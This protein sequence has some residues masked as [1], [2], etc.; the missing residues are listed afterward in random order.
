MNARLSL[1]IAALCL[2]LA[3]A[4]LGRWQWQRGEEKAA[5]LAAWNAALTAPDSALD[6][7]VAATGNLPQRVRGEGRFHGPW[8]L[9]DNQRHQGVVGLRV[10]R[11]LEVCCEGHNVLVDLGWR[12]W[13]EGRRAPA[14]VEL[15]DPA[16]VAG[17]LVP[18]PGQ[19]IALGQTDWTA[20]TD[21]A[22]LLLRIERA[23]LEQHLGLKLAPRVL[24]L[25]PG[26]DFGFARDLEALP[27]TL[28]PERHRGY[29]VQWFALSLTVLIV[30]AVLLWRSLR[31]DRSRPGNLSP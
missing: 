30:T 20:S 5:L 25:D 19:G 8:I 24:R 6:K 28:P 23:E 1:T 22:V 21:N 29:A 16:D 27:N 26:A 13:E 10:Y 3:F 11:A 18:W 31:R 7:A 12:P 15:P 14:P 4:T 9:L 2:A 17:L